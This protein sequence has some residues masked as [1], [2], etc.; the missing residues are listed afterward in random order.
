MNRKSLTYNLPGRKSEK[1]E[2]VSNPG[3]FTHFDIPYDGH[4]PVPVREVLEDVAHLGIHVGMRDSFRPSEVEDELP[5]DQSGLG[6]ATYYPSRNQIH[7]GTG[8]YGGRVSY[9]TIG[10]AV[11]ASADNRDD[12]HMEF[13]NGRGTGINI[14]VYP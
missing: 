7:Y 6:E 12:V 11:V 1:V 9:Q 3:D 13:D 4:I 5:E 10:V 2:T 14:T 8:G